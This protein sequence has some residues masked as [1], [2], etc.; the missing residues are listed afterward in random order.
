MSGSR[1]WS[2]V[3]VSAL[4]GCA[5]RPADPPPPPPASAPAP[6]PAEPSPPPAAAP[7]ATPAVPTTPEASAMPPAKPAQA[8]APSPAPVVPQ[9]PAAKPSAPAATP[10]PEAPAAPAP[11]PAATAPSKATV[12]AG[13]LPSLAANGHAATG[14]AKCKPCHRTQHDS[15]SAGPHRGIALDCEAC[16]GNGADYKA[17]SVMKDA[18]AAKAAGLKVPDLAFCRKCH[19]GAAPALLAKAHA[20]KA[21]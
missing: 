17:G 21:K 9:V 16:H 19:A 6:A 14:G 15:W 11:A 20:H 1:W 5:Q 7:A 10:A 3:L 8:A 13:P 12:P 4:A 18:A 2:L